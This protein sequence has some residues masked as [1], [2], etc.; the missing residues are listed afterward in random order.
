MERTALITS[1]MQFRLSG[2][3]AW[4]VPCAH[5]Y[6]YPIKGMAKH[7]GKPRYH[8]EI[9]SGE[10]EVRVSLVCARYFPLTRQSQRQPMVWENGNGKACSYI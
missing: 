6:R 1:L 5:V 4:V 2:T 10:S 3:A 7:E 9:D 8:K